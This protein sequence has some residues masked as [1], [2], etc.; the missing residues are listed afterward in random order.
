MLE[1][2]A[3]FDRYLVEAL[4]GSGGMGSVYR[5]YDEKLQRRIALKVLLTTEATDGSGPSDGKARLLR[6]ARAAAAL[7]HPN[8]VALFDVGEHDGS[9]YIAMELVSGQ[10][11]RARL[12]DLREPWRERLRWLADIGRAL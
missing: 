5:A 3:R 2:G 6:E 11:L 10:S 12:A 8:A 1:A 4:L 9:P 7:Q